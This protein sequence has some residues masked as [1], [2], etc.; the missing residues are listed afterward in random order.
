MLQVLYDPFTAFW[1]EGQ[2]SKSVTP[3]TG[4]FSMCCSEV[5][6]TECSNGTHVQILNCFAIY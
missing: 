5:N 3:S 1:Y 2:E 6:V 4:P